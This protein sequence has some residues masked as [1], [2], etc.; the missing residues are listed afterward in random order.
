MDVCGVPVLADD[1]DE[2]ERT[3]LH[4]AGHLA[5][6]AALGYQP[7]G[8]TVRGGSSMLGCSTHTLGGLADG[9]M[10][11][12]VQALSD[13]LPFICWPAEMRGR[14]EA[15]TVIKLAGQAAEL[16][17]AERTPATARLPATVAEQ[18]AQEAAELPEPPSAL[19]QKYVALVDDPDAAE[20]DATGLAILAAAA[21]GD[22][23]ASMH[24]WLS[25]CEC[26][27][28][29]LVLAEAPKIRRLAGVLAL[30]HTLDGSAVAALLR[31]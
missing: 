21:H 11:G 14:V 28:R 25:Y 13:G 26:Q 12:A 1:V 9:V 16:A 31:G 7:V 15:L 19:V 18:A 20:S 4:E 23:L 29:A 3:R 30:R 27:A 5:V 6:G 17:L 24:A 8:V 10:Q 22:D 2:D